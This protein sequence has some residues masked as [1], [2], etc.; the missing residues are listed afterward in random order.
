MS[1]RG[2]FVLDGRRILA[3]PFEDQIALELA[4][5][6]LLADLKDLGRHVVQSDEEVRRRLRGCRVEFGVRASGGGFK[7]L[8]LPGTGRRA[9][10]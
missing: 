7:R 4:R 6:W 1:V 5:T 10:A 8:P 2:W 3:G 9:T